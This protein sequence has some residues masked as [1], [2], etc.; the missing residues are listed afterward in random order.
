MWNDAP[1]KFVFIH[2]DKLDSFFR[3]A[4]LSSPIEQAV[5]LILWIGERCERSDDPA[6]FHPVPYDALAS[7]IGSRSSVAAVDYVTRYADRKQWIEIDAKHIS[8]TRGYR[9]TFA[10]WERYD[11][12]RRAKA[13]SRRAFMAMQFNNPELTDAYQ[14]CFK[15][16]ASDAGFTLRLLPDG[17]GAGLIDDQLRVAIRTAKFLVVDLT[18]G[19]R[20]AYWEAGF[21]E[22][23]G[24]PVIYVC[25]GDVL[26]DK[27]HK[28][29][30]HFDT[31]HLNTVPW[32]PDALSDAR[33]RLGATIQNTFPTEAI[34]PADGS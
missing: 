3:D 23:L 13:D 21:A 17:Q 4:R 31:N 18:T 30:P 32:M 25:R 27:Q 28:D 2:H 7:I 22:G 11:E 15:L 6:S 10:G 29:H 14:N 33:K 19:N 1:G 26:S 5:N 34:M 16:A 20:G 12:L 8:G 24:R 9:L